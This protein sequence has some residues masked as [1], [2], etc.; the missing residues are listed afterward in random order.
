MLRQN[1]AIAHVLGACVHEGI[2]VVQE[3]R[4]ASTA[5][6]CQSSRQSQAP[7]SRRNAMGASTFDLSSVPGA[8]LCPRE[9]KRC[10]GRSRRLRPRESRGGCLRENPPMPKLNTLLSDSLIA[11][12]PSELPSRAWPCAGFVGLHSTNGASVLGRPRGGAPSPAMPTNVM[13][14]QARAADYSASTRGVSW[15]PTTKEPS[16]SPS[17]API[18]RGS[19]T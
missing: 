12:R 19:D 14:G 3:L 10:G 1:V 7:R 8:L 9:A 16:L 15:S 11:P 17:E 2:Y 4:P 18:S 6:R 13:A 5:V